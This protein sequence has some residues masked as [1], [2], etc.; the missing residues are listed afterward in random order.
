[1]FSLPCEGD[2]ATSINLTGMYNCIIAVSRRRTINCD[3]CARELWIILFDNNFACTFH[4]TFLVS[5]ITIV[6]IW[7][8]PDCRL[9]S[10]TGNFWSSVTWLGGEEGRDLVRQQFAKG[11]SLFSNKKRQTIS[12]KRGQ[13][14]LSGRV[15]HSLKQRRPTIPLQK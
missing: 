7:Q 2:L 8:Q 10:V 6:K 4:L 11:G 12:N 9:Q 15:H 1:M 5:N 14:F 13:S 3:M